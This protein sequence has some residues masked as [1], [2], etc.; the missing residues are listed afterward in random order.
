ME[1][2]NARKIRDGVVVSDKMD[3]TVVVAEQTMT[4]HPLYKKR[5]KKTRKYKVHDEENSCKVGDKVKI[6]ET[7]PLSK[8]KCWRVMEIIE[9]AE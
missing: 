2:R 9:K 8:E 3:K 7:K 4:I 5:V 1:A 6:M